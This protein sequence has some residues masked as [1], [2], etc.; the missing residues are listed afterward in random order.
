MPEEMLRRKEV[1]RLLGVHPQTVVTWANKGLLPPDQELPSG[2]R[3][4]LRSTVEQVLVS[5]GGKA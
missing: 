3:R 2:E 1:A 5:L 4:W